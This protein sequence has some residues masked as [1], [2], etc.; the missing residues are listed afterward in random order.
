M[1]LLS[2]DVARTALLASAQTIPEIELLDPADAL[3]RVLA[4]DL[5]SPLTVPPFDNAA[6]DGYALRAADVPV[7]GTRLPVSQR[8]TAGASGAP[9]APGSAARIFTGAPLPAG[10]D[11]VVM[12]EQ[13]EAGEGEVTITIQP[14]RGDHVRLA[15]ADIQA[16]S[17][18]LKAGTRLSAA[19]LGLAASV[20]VAQLAV[21]RRLRVAIFSTGDELRMPGQ[22]LGPGQIYNSNRYVMRGFLQ[23]L[24]LE[25]V[26]LGI[27]ADDRESTRAALRQAAEADVILA[28][29]GMSEGEE[30]HVAA[31]VR[32]EGR[33]DVW[34]IAMKPGKPLAFGSVGTTPFIGLPGN[35]VAVWVGL[36]L[37][38]QPFLAIRSGMP[39]PAMASQKLRADFSWKVKGNRLEFIRVR[40]NEQGGLDCYP[41]QSS[42]VL[43]SA[44][45]ADGLAAVAPGTVIQPGDLLDFTPGPAG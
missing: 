12:Q 7:A 8:I 23:S 32:A 20:G 10:A 35:P 27:V 5:V 26:D 41:D 33:L 1:T 43:S 24:G 39:A 36:L 11:T 15:G 45:W 34:K 31:A 9:L 37:L 14:D 22:P 13:C 29:G 38:V 28:S 6:M 30:D 4:E 18:I 16:G 17:V 44:V 40:K 21:R 2:F 19:A 3:G 42:G 25:V